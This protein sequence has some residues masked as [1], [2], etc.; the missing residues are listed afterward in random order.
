MYALCAP[1]WKGSRSSFLARTSSP[2]V[3]GSEA[4]VEVSGLLQPDKAVNACAGMP[5]RLALFHRNWQKRKG[6]P[7]VANRAEQTWLFTTKLNTQEEMMSTQ[8]GKRKR[9]AMDQSGYVQP[10]S[11]VAARKLAMQRQDLLQA[12]SLPAPSVNDEDMQEYGDVAESSQSSR[13]S[14]SNE[15]IV[16]GHHEGK[17]SISSKLTSPVYAVQRQQRYF[18]SNVSFAPASEGELDASA[19]E[20]DTEPEAST[21]SIPPIFFQGRRRPKRRRHPDDSNKCA[22][23]AS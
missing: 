1:R 9:I 20:D 3:P 5:R 8:P 21:S 11:A 14:S 4:F 15:D 10:L 18:Q 13:A 7:S 2:A 19:G 23:L 22:I 17:Q 16:S 6:P 12:E